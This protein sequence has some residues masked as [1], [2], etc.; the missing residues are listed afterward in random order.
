MMKLRKGRPLLLIDI[1]VPCDIDPPSPRSKTFTST[2]LTTSRPSQPINL[3][4]RQ[5]EIGALRSHHPR[6]VKGL[7]ERF[8]PQSGNAMHGG[9]RVEKEV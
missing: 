6:K 4:Q 8:D 3:K 9:L 7:L 2:I 5:E 1:A